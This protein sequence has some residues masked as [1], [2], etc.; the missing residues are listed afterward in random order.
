MK[1]TKSEREAAKAKRIDLAHKAATN[2]G[3]NLVEPVHAWNLRYA[4]AYLR[5]ALA[6]V[7]RAR[8]LDRAR[9]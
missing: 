3:V 7:R 9:S 6:H 1:Y 4:E 5:E 2:A 8:K